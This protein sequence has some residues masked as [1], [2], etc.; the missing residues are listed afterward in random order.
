MWHIGID[1]CPRVVPRTEC[2]TSTLT[3]IAP[4]RIEI[5]IRGDRVEPGRIARTES[6]SDRSDLVTDGRP[7]SQRWHRD[8]AVERSLRRRPEQAFSLRPPSVTGSVDVVSTLSRQAGPLH[9]GLHRTRSG[10]KHGG[11]NCGRSIPLGTCHLTGPWQPRRLAFL[12]PD[13][14]QRVDQA[15]G[16]RL[17]VQLRPRTN[18]VV[19]NPL[20]E[21]IKRGA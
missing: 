21:L 1:A 20:V 2:A 18:L 3:T 14:W 13:D 12:S 5:T 15:D 10:S 8:P 17:V 4:K 11:A 6:K 7:G 9:H 16:Q 19:G